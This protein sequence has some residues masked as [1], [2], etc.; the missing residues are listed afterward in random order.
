MATGL[1]QTTDGHGSAMRS[2]AGLR[3]TM[4]GGQIS[5]ITAGSGSRE[6]TL[7]GDRHGS[8]GGPVAI[9]LAGRLCRHAVLGSFIKDS[10]LALAWT[11]NSILVHC[12]T[13]FAMCVLSAS[14]CCATAFFRRCRTSLI[15]KTR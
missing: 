11:S 14:R 6:K 10:L 1:I 3:T 15:S 13:T 7:I 8:H 12:I 9:T 4:V 5:P 2:L